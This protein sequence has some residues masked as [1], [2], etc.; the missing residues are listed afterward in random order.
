MDRFDTFPGLFSPRS[1][2]RFGDCTE[3]RS[4]CVCGYQQFARTLTTFARHH[5]KEKSPYEG[6]TFY[7]RVNMT[8]QYPINPPEIHFQTK[9]YHPSV[10]K[11]GDDQGKLCK[12]LI[13][14]CEGGPTNHIAAA[15]LADIICPPLGEG[16]GCFRFLCRQRPACWPGWWHALSF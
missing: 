4:D 1:L 7:I 10:K 14:R 13:K 9:I 15:A 8:A 6:G 16:E 3:T 11:D 12:D 2:F 5:P